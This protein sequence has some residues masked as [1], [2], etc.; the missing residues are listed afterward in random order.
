MRARRLINGAP[1]GPSTVKAMAR[2]FDQA[3]AEV[4]GNFG[5]S[6]SEVESARLRLAR[7]MLSVAAEGSTDVAKLRTSAVQTMAMQN[8]SACSG[9]RP[10]A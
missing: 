7:A 4:A 10:A 1:F 8:R 2:A 6:A 9:I 3:W 5:D